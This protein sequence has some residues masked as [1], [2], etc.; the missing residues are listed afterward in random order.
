MEE[1]DSAD[2][3]DELDD[4]DVEEDGNTTDSDPEDCDFWLQLVTRLGCSGT[5]LLW[6][7]SEV[8]EN[9][10]P[11]DDL[12]LDMRRSIV[13]EDAVIIGHPGSYS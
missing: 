10:L 11:I 13:E 3:E 4:M 7:L 2:M 8:L 6:W 5:Q 12:L 9:S 1:E